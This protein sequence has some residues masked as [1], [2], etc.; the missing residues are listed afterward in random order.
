VLSALSRPS[1]SCRNAASPDAEADLERLCSIQA[2]AMSEER[3]KGQLMPHNGKNLKKILSL[4]LC[5]A[6]AGG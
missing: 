4:G 6:C 2:K 1:T 5:A 3:T